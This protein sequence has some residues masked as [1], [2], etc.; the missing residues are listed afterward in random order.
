V[1]RVAVLIPVLLVVVT[2]VLGDTLAAV[3]SRFYKRVP[4][5]R[6]A[7]YSRAGARIGRMDPNSLLPRPKFLPDANT[8]ASE[9]RKFEGLEEAIKKVCRGRQQEMRDWTRAPAEET[10]QL[11][12]AVHRQITE[13]LAFIR[14][15]AVAEGSKKTVAAIDAITQERHKRYTEM[16]SKMEQQRRRMRLGEFERP[17][18]R[19]NRRLTRGRYSERDR[20][21]DRFG[22]RETYRGRER[23]DERYRQRQGYTYPDRYGQRAPESNEYRYPQRDR[24]YDR[25]A[26]ERSPQG[27]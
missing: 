20:Y 25:S 22:R 1:K 14:D 18:Q 21:G 7:P 3:R 6:I 2:F 4:R 5:E 19:N 10:I 27:R 26:R 8:I 11:A 24:E 9:V 17:Y 13:E 15:I 23:Y 16:I 12:R